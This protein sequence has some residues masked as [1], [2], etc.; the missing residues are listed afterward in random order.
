[1]RS[2]AFGA[3]TDDILDTWSARQETVLGLCAQCAC[4]R[5]QVAN[6]RENACPAEPV[7]DIGNITVWKKAV[8]FFNFGKQSQQMGEF[9]NRDPTHNPLAVMDLKG[10]TSWLK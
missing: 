4:H 3:R 9:V 7:P 8:N 5:A 6:F 10:K 1:M 2:G